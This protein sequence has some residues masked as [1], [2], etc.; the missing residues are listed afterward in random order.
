MQVCHKQCPAVCGYQI[1][2]LK[3]QLG[4]Q[5]SIIKL[6]ISFSYLKKK[7][8]KNIEVQHMALLSLLFLYNF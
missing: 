6:L 4:L 8:P 2:N 5:F 3:I 1:Q 7:K